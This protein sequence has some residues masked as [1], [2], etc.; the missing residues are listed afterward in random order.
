[1]KK[2]ELKLEAVPDDR[3]FLMMGWLTGDDPE[4][5]IHFS[6]SCGAGMGNPRLLLSVTVDGTTFRESVDIRDVTREWVGQ[7]LAEV[8][9]EGAV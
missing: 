8:R 4:S 9:G 6:L 5:D 2:R 7:I 3:L 1:M